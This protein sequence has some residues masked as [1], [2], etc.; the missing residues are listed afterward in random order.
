MKPSTA[1]A[2]AML[3]GGGVLYDS[4]AAPGRSEIVMVTNGRYLWNRQTWWQKI[5]HQKQT[6]F[7]V[8]VEYTY[9]YDDVTGTSFGRI[10]LKR[11]ENNE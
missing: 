2:I 3:Q 1:A 11:G 7:A 6:W 5:L 4:L 9:R 10:Y 8:E